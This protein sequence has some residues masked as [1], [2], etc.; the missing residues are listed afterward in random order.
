MSTTDYF[1]LVR[2]SERKYLKIIF[3]TLR[4][5]Q[6]KPTLSI[7]LVQKS[8]KQNLLAQAR[9]ALPLL[10][11]L[12]ADWRWLGDGKTGAPLDEHMLALIAPEKTLPDFP[13]SDTTLRLLS[14]YHLF[15]VKHKMAHHLLPLAIIAMDERLRSNGRGDSCPKLMRVWCASYTELIWHFNISPNK[16]VP[17]A[18]V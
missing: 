16:F 10:W 12:W 8:S 15:L 3:L 14:R 5:A 11:A 4:A 2:K 1:K 6:K 13:W 7:R 9:V 17:P 18:K